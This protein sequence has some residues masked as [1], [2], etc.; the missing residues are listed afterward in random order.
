MNR[1]RFVAAPEQPGTS[2]QSYRHLP[3]SHV[4][5]RRSHSSDRILDVT[6][7]YK[8][9]PMP[10]IPYALS[11]SLS[12]AYRKWRFSKLPVFKTR[13][14]ADFQK[15]LAV[16]R[17]F[18]KIWGNAYL[19][20]KLGDAVVRNLERG[21]AILR[22]RYL[23]KN[24]SDR[25]EDAATKSSDTAIAA[26]PDTSSTSILSG[27]TFPAGPVP[28][29]FSATMGSFPIMGDEQLPVAQGMDNTDLSSFTLSENVLAND[30][31]IF[32]SWDKNF[33]QMIDNSFASYLDP[34]NPFGSCEYLGFT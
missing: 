28:L 18:G 26:P 23:N 33:T 11:L 19:S 3:P 21:E 34:G 16:L 25:P 10:F 14:K 15:V 22:W 29:P 6:S 4:N 30:S 1:D 9:S 24:S 13:G 31:V 20:V 5:A 32:E 27:S 8:L 7:D 2:D 12:V 17:D